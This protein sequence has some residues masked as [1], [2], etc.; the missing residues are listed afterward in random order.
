M[1]NYQNDRAMHYFILP[2]PYGY[3]IM[4]V[5]SE[6]VPLF[7][8]RFGADILCEAATLGELLLQFAAKLES[9]PP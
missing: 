1:L 9:N 6:D 2:D 7:Q 5:Q 4:K 8:K 3:K